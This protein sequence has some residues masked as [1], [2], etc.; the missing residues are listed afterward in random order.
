MRKY[1]DIT[2]DGQFEYDGKILKYRLSDTD[3]SLSGSKH[4]IYTRGVSL[5]DDTAN[6]EYFKICYDY[7]N[8]T[9]TSEFVREQYIKYKGT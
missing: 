4:K 8:N 9:I 6:N 3:I 2:I 1:D 5:F 7:D